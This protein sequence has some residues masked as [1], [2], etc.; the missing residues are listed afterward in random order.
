MR[1]SVAILI[2]LASA[3][4]PYGLLTL[5]HIG[6]NTPHKTYRLSVRPFGTILP[7]ENFLVFLRLGDRA[8]L[9]WRR[10]HSSV[11]CML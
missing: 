2:T 7:G 4:R 3:Q 8:A 1:R 9:H 10:H 5:S 11:R 6:R